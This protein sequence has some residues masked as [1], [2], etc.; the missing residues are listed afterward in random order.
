M[1]SIPYVYL[2]YN[3]FLPTL[4]LNDF[5]APIV[6]LPL[7]LVLPNCCKIVGMLMASMIKAKLINILNILLNKFAST[8]IKVINPITIHIL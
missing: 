7:P 1:L 8:F 4:L 3:H 5:K 2:A 6:A